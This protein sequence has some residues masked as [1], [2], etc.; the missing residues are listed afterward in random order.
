MLFLSTPNLKFSDVDR[1]DL[2]AVAVVCERNLMSYE[3]EDNGTAS[4]NPDEVVTREEF[5]VLIMNV[6]TTVLN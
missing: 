3:K 6:K 2:N 5:I 4:F 1:L